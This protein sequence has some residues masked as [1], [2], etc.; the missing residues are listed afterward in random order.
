MDAKDV[1]VP[2]MNELYTLIAKTEFPGIG[3][4]YETLRKNIRDS[5]LLVS[6]MKLKLARQDLLRYKPEPSE[7]E[8]FATI[9]TNLTV[10]LDHAVIPSDPREL[11]IAAVKKHDPF[12]LGLALEDLPLRPELNVFLLS[13]IS[14]EAAIALM[15][16]EYYFVTKFFYE[17]RKD[18]AGFYDVYARMVIIYIL[19]S[20][21]NPFDHA[22]K[23][24]YTLFPLDEEEDAKEGS[25]DEDIVCREEAPTTAGTRKLKLPDEVYER[26][27]G[28]WNRKAYDKARQSLAYAR[29]LLRGMNPYDETAEALKVLN[30]PPDTPAAI[31]ILRAFVPSVQNERDK[32]NILKAIDCLER[33]QNI[34]VPSQ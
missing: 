29:K 21:Y 8:L 12:L 19:R 22:V 13:T 32:K 17:I 4:A 30:A 11:L 31:E 14:T 24:L 27:N 15:L 5:T 16:K 3:R 9:V 25:S 33:Y 18:I 7:E 10:Y 6:I 23:P 20:L 28:T 2:S 26:Q 34:T 1:I